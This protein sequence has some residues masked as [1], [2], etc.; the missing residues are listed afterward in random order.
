MRVGENIE[1]KSYI[2]GVIR[3][4]FFID[5][6]FTSF[7]LKCLKREIIEQIRKNYYTST[8]L[9]LEGENEMGKRER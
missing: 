8:P 2:E 1:K 6:L 3:R 4:Y 9:F 5:V 7:I